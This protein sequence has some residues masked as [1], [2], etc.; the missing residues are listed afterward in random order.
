VKLADAQGYDP[1]KLPGSNVR[2]L[3]LEAG[4][5]LADF[6]K[7]A[8]RQGLKWGPGRVSDLEGGRVEAKLDTLLAVA[9]VLANLT[10]RPVT[11]PELFEG[12]PRAEF[13][14]G[15][16]VQPSEQTD[17]TPTEVVRR[18]GWPDLASAAAELGVTEDQVAPVLLAYEETGLVDQRAA[19]AL[20][21][22]VL[23]LTCHTV[24]LW[25]H[26]FEA[27]RDRLAGPNAHAARQGEVTRQLRQQ[28][29]DR[30]DH[31]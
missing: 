8:K 22:S 19:K 18:N 3:R 15:E 13:L 30:L 10:G 24:A 1:A 5:T 4:V 25:G 23:E 16:P 12:D 26:N 9:Q 27:E 6:A 20:G 14:G 7:E 2:R 28:V 17:A 29:Q 11:L 21:L 31:N